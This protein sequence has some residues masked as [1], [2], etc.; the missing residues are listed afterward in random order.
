[1]MYYL[2][3]QDCVG[4]ILSDNVCNTYKKQITKQVLPDSDFLMAIAPQKRGKETGTN[5]DA[6]QL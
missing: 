3:Q 1:M 2:F 4:V 6:N 5:I